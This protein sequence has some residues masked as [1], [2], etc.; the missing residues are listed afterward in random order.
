[1]AFSLITPPNFGSGGGSCFPVIVVVA[2]GEPGVPLISWE[3]V[4]RGTNMAVVTVSS[5]AA[6]LRSLFFGLMAFLPL[7]IQIRR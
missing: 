7:A 1:V 2:L 4:G 5:E 3:C 6:K